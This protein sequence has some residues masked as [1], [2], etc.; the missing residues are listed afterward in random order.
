MQITLTSDPVFAAQGLRMVARHMLGG[1]DTATAHPTR[2]V[3]AADAAE[4]L[5]MD[6]VSLTGRDQHDHEIWKGINTLRDC[7]HV[8]SH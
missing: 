3:Q 4:R 8:R 6:A 2:M 1:F 5:L 7:A